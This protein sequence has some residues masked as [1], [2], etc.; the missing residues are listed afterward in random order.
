[1]FQTHAGLS[2]LYEVSCKELDILVT[3]IQNNPAVLGA[4]MMGGGFGGCTLNIVRE[5]AIPALVEFVSHS[6]TLLTGLKCKTYI[7][8]IEEGTGI[9]HPNN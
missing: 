5:E 7:A 6:Y 3:L 4:R 1:M 8:Q 9:I 2:K